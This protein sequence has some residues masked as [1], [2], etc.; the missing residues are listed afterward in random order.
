MDEVK[1]QSIRKGRRKLM[2]RY[3]GSDSELSNEV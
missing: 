3:F 1:K 2:A